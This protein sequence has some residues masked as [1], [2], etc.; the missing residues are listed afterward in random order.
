MRSAP[1]RRGV[2]DDH[3]SGADRRNFRGTLTDAAFERSRLRLGVLRP[4]QNK[5]HDYEVTWDG[6]R[7]FAFEYGD[8]RRHLC[9]YATRFNGHVIGDQQDHRK[10]LEEGNTTRAEFDVSGQ[11]KV[12]PGP[13]R[14]PVDRPNRGQGAV[15]ESHE[16]VVELRQSLLCCFAERNCA[17]VASV[18]AF[19]RSGSLTV[20]SATPSFA[21]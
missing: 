12:E 11:R 20:I 18:T 6:S 9:E 5:P 8:D 15:G 4:Q 2:R 10:L 14:G 3:R 16:S 21:R 19:L 7:H 13:D 1:T 17:D